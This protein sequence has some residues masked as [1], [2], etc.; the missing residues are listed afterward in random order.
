MSIQKLSSTIRLR[1]HERA[2]SKND[3]RLIEDVVGKRGNAV[4]TP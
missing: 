1:H 4:L 3:R 2:V